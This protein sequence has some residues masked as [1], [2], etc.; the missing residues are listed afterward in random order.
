MDM[1]YEATKKSGRVFKRGGRVRA[2]NETYFRELIQRSAE[3]TEATR[4]LR[5]FPLRES[6]HHPHRE[7][8]AK[9]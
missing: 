2:Y 9:P 1:D 6:V 8:L 5:C 3:R 7:S 4:N